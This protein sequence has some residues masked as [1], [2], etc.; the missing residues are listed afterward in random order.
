[1][2][3][4]AALPILA[5]GIQGAAPQAPVVAPAQMKLTDAAP[6]AIA[7]KMGDDVAVLDTTMGRIVLKFFPDQAPGHVKNFTD[8]AKKGFYDGTKFH[9]VIKG[10]MI[11]GGDPLTKDDAKMSAWGTGGPG[12]TIKAEFNDISHTPGILSMARTSDPDTAGSQFFIVHKTSKTLDRQYTVF[13]Q[14]IDGMKVVN[15]IATTPT[16]EGDRPVT[17]VVIKTV[18]I[19]SW[20]LKS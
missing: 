7:P 12:Y 11:Q 6:G 15:K 13:G 20:P 5:L 10:F 17:P 4:L 8:L 14:V 2:S 19:E 1:M 3:I 16:A 18:K 9:R